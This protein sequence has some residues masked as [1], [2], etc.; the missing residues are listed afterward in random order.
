LIEPNCDYMSCHED[1]SFRW[2]EILMVPAFVT[3]LVQGGAVRVPRDHLISDRPVSYWA[4][5]VN[6]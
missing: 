6:Y 4:C 5:V 2:E 3:K 1:E